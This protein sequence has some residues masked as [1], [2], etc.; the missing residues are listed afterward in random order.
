V[1]ASYF[2]WYQNMHGER[3]LADHVRERL[4][5]KM[6]AASEAVYEVSQQQKVHLRTAALI[7]AL[8]RVQDAESLQISAV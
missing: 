1:T 2:E 7:L 8:Q 5:Q 4:H 3:W 6:V